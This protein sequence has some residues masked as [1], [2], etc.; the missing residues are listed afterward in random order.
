LARHIQTRLN[1]VRIRKA[2]LNFTVLGI[3]LVIG[4]LLSELLAR[5]ILSPS[6]YLQVEMVND[7]VL[8]ATPSPSTLGHGFDR[9]GFRNAD[10]PET[11]DIVAIGDSHTYGNTATMQD[12]WPYVVGG[13]SGRRTYNMGLG[14]YGPNQYFHL[15]K[16]KALTL[17]PRLII[18]GLYMGDDFENAYLITYGLDHWK[19]LRAL[20]PEKV[21]FNI[22]QAPPATS[23][24]KPIRI[25]FSR[26]SLVYQLLVHGPFTGRFQGEYQIRNAS[27]LYPS[28]T[29]LF[30]PEKNIEEAFL[31]E[32]ILRRL[33]QDDETVREGMRITFSLLSQMNDICR[34][35]GIRFMVAV[36]PTKE[37]VFAEYLEGNKDLPL[38]NVIARLLSNERVAR[39]KTFKSLTAS[40]I[41]YVDT[42]PALRNEVEHQLYARTAADIHPNKNGYGVIGKAIVAALDRQTR[43]ER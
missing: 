20:P 10:V 16:T 42:L 9:W 33:N 19:S 22:W 8:G 14:G 26:H 38:G 35:D 36:I 21:N 25:W 13:L 39:E 18:T 23:W 12:S 41:S 32:G 3:A 37:M 5:F 2:F 29:A 6:D 31:P 4:L 15:L 24:H 17:K 34:Q 1:I 30:V 7:P 40:G 28:A 27:K 11:A 43:A